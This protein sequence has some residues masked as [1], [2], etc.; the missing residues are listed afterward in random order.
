MTYSQRD[1]KALERSAR[2]VAEA[3]AV[4]MRLG[5]A[6]GSP[7]HVHDLEVND[8]ELKSLSG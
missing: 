7:T 8:A 6:D 3:L 2:A 1:H 5:H 4:A